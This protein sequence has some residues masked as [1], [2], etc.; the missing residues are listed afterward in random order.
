MQAVRLQF[1]LS[2][3]VCFRTRPGSR[4]RP[5]GGAGPDRL[6]PRPRRHQVSVRQPLGR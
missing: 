5:A 3:R 1:L 2:T 6:P 4:C